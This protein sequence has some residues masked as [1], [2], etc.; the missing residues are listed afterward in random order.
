LGFIITI[1]NKSISRYFNNSHKFIIV[2]DTIHLSL[3]K[4]KRVTYNI[5]ISKVYSIITSINKVYIIF[6]ALK[7][8]TNYIRLF[9]ILIIRYMNSYLLYKY[10]IKL[11]RYDKIEKAYN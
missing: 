1:A 11:A 8:V 10:Y 5:L 2:R 7:I 4:Y 9:L 3:I 6:I